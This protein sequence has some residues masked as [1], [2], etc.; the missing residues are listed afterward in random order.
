MKAKGIITFRGPKKRSARWLGMRRPKRPTPLIIKRSLML[1]LSEM[2]S[3]LRPKEP[4]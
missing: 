3:M 1:E 4:I 2:W